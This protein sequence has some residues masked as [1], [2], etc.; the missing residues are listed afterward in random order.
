MHQPE[1]S[2]KLLEQTYSPRYYDSIALQAEY[3][4]A[5]TLII[6][7]NNLHIGLRVSD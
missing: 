7:P 2:G 1:K 3:W 6:L 4:P 5:L